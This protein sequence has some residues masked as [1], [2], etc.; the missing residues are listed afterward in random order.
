LWR[1]AKGSEFESI[2]LDDQKIKTIWSDFFRLHLKSVRRILKREESEKIDIEWK[3]LQTYKFVWSSSQSE[4]I[5]FRFMF[6]PRRQK[7][8]LS[9]SELDRFHSIEKKSV[10]NNDR[11]LYIFE[12]AN[13]ARPY[14]LSRIHESFPKRLAWCS[15]NEIPENSFVEIYSS[16]DEQKKRNHK[17]TLSYSDWKKTKVKAEQIKRNFNQVSPLPISLIQLKQDVDSKKSYLKF[18]TRSTEHGLNLENILCQLTIA[19][20]KNRS[21]FFVAEFLG[22]FVPKDLNYEKNLDLYHF[23]LPSMTVYSLK[24][25]FKDLDNLVK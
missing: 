8:L 7:W 22:N 1:I 6:W 15:W 24:K 20:L 2:P 12:L 23:V 13:E 5:E 10:I 21:D 19:P 9:M 17:K 25:I 14:F 11:P 16:F 4:G 3:T 18:F